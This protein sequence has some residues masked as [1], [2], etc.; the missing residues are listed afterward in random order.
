[1]SINYQE[2]LAY[3][4][5]YLDE[6]EQLRAIRLHQND[7]EQSMYVQGRLIAIQDIRGELINNHERWMGHEQDMKGIKFAAFCHEQQVFSEFIQSSGRKPW[8]IDYWDD[9]ET[10]SEEE[11]L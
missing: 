4:E 3:L 7:F 9:M 5:K 11:A 1:M 2:F 10:E 8:S 6:A